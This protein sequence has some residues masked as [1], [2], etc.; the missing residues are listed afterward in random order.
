MTIASNPILAPLTSGSSSPRAVILTHTLTIALGSAASGLRLSDRE[1]WTTQLEL[2]LTPLDAAEPSESVRV[3]LIDGEHGHL[4]PDLLLGVTPEPDGYI[5][6]TLTIE[7]FQVPLVVLKADREI[8][9]AM[10][11]RLATHLADTAC[12]S[13]AGTLDP[14]SPVQRKPVTGFTFTD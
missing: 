3:L 6:G 7:P 1:Q 13:I 10:A 2:A 14:N 11:N 4:E 5:I 9:L 8:I 12:F